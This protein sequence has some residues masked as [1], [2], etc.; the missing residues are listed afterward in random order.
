MNI[1]VTSRISSD[2]EKVIKIANEKNVNI[3]ISDILKSGFNEKN[4]SKTVEQYSNHLKNFK[5][6][7]SIHGCCGD[8][9]PVS[10]DPKIKQV[11]IERYQLSFDVA[12]E[13]NA[14]T[15]VFHSDFVPFGR[16][17]EH[18]IK[19]LILKD[20]EFWQTFIRQFEDAG[21]TA[22]I[23]NVYD[24][25]PDVI[26]SII[27]GVNSPNLKCCLDTGHAN[28]ISDLSLCEWLKL[29]GDK[30]HHIHAHNNS[31]EYDEHNGFNDGTI[32]FKKL[33]TCLK[34]LNINPNI[35]IEVFDRKEALESIDIIKKFQ[36]MQI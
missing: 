31:K 23:E 25:S 30:L 12:K 24:P 15:I 17:K 14:T 4:L 18:Y 26:K 34:D 7:I 6:K 9:N 11:S 29:F 5:G 28:I 33:F 36:E 27:E 20:I 13:L 21:I 19:K 32:D 2:F 35:V 1:Y 22:V 8:I 10:K 16:S 3:E